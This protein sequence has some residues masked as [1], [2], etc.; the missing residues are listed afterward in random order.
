M[1][2]EHGVV[3]VGDAVLQIPLHV[4]L[5]LIQHLSKTIPKEGVVIIRHFQRRGSSGR[6]GGKPN[7]TFNYIPYVRSRTGGNFWLALFRRPRGSQGL[8]RNSVQSA[9]PRTS[10]D[11]ES[12]RRTSCFRTTTTTATPLAC[13]TSLSISL[14][15]SPAG[16]RSCS[17]FCSSS[18]ADTSNLARIA[19]VSSRGPN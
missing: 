15:S 2:R 11:E 19:Y 17:I 4:H 6:W 13:S 8:Q 16:S 10:D 14:N 5:A 12:N 9:P 1:H 18:E 3:V 7:R